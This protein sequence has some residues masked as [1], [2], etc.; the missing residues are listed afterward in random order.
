MTSAA[1]CKPPVVQLVVLTQ[2]IINYSLVHP[3]LQSPRSVA[4]CEPAAPRR[5]VDGNP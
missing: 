2:T 4:G 3:I 5:F 1:D